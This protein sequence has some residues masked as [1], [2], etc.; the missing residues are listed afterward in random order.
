[1]TAL[2]AGLAAHDVDAVM[3]LFTDDSALFGSDQSEEALDPAAIR[4]FVSRLVGLPFTIAWSWQVASAG[5]EGDVA[6]F[7]A[8]A[9]YTGTSPDGSEVDRLDPYRMSGV[10]RRD[11]DRWRFVLLNGSAPQ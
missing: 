11:G 10:L 3:E 2:V 7:V 8:H 5:R 6:W 9:V 4:D 1:M